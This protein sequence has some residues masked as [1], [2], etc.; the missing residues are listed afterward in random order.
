[1][2]QKL[3]VTLA[4][5]LRFCVCGSI[6][7]F[8]SLA[9]SLRE[10]AVASGHLLALQRAFIDALICGLVQVCNWL[11]SKYIFLTTTAGGLSH[12]YKMTKPKFVH[13]VWTGT[14]QHSVQASSTVV[15]GQ[16]KSREKVTAKWRGRVY[17]ATIVAVGMCWPIVITALIA[18]TR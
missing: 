4:T 3:T 12:H 6:Y 7:L 9:V 11:C 14:E 10:E 1:M 5:F 8:Y 15:S 18:I 2:R 16:I 13:L 17:S